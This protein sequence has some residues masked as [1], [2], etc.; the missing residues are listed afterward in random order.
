[1]T[2]ANFNDFL[3]LRFKNNFSSV[4]LKVMSFEEYSGI[5]NK[6]AAGFLWCGIMTVG[7][8]YPVAYHIECRFGSAKES[9]IMTDS[10]LGWGSNKN[11]EDAMKKTIDGMVSKFAVQFFKTR[12][13]I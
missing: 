1:M 10:V 9:Q 13:G 6:D 8:T 3:R 4:A 7:D 12:G 2:E 11:V 5:K